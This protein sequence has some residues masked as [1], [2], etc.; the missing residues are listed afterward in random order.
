MT[1]LDWIAIAMIVYFVV[2]GL[3]KGVAAALLGEAAV[4]LA[5]AIAAIALPAVGDLVTGLVRSQA[6]DWPHW[7][8]LVAF[9][10]T[11]LIV[12]GLFMVLVSIMPGGK[13]PSGPA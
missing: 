10:A 13:R 4:I 11:F 6:E 2:Q 5:Y 12:Y 3:L 7:A 8:R 1:W 9:V